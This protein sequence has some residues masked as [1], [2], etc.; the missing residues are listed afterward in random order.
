MIAVRDGLQSGAAQWACSKRTPLRAS[1]SMFGV[2]A[3]GWP[4]RQPTLSFISS[5][6]MNRTLGLSAALSFKPAYNTKG[7]H[8]AAASSTLPDAKSRLVVISN[9]F[10]VVFPKQ[11]YDVRP[12]L[13]DLVEVNFHAS[14]IADTCVETGK[15]FIPGA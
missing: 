10:R 15:F 5:T 6:E 9:L 12:L 7:R 3:C 1:L 14:R 11:L 8:H 2:F 13:F 4:P